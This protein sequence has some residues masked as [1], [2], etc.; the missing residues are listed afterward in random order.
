MQVTRRDF[1]KFCGMMAAMMGLGST[2][3]AQ[4]A[5]ALET[6]SRIILS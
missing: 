6:K 4:V 2:G 3:A 1:L 5:K